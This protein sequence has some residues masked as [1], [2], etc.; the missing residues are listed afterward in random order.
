[1]GNG[2]HLWL[3]LIVVTALLCNVASTPVQAHGLRTGYLEIEDAGAGQATVRFRLPVIAPRVRPQ[4]PSD[5]RSKPLNAPVQ[6]DSGVVT[7]YLV[8]CERDL[9]GREVKIAGLGPAVSEA[10]VYYVSPTGEATAVLL[11]RKQDT[12]SIP[13]ATE[14]SVRGLCWHYAQLGLEH[15]GSGVDHLLFVA[16]LVL[17]LQRIRAVLTA[18]LAFT[19]SHTLSYA[20]TALGWLRLPVPATEACIA[21]SLVLLALD[22]DVH[23]RPAVP[24]AAVTIWLPLCFGL[25]HGLG[26][27]GGLQDVG[28]PA[29]HAGLATLGFGLGVELGQLASALLLLG[30]AWLASRQRVYIPIKYAATYCIGGTATYWFFTRLAVVIG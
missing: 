4:L 23:K 7:S 14:A 11:S 8:R 10:A 3:A 9:A 26:F 27:A 22:V 30:V 17:S 1:M 16:L 5:C 12:W 19:C 15:I 6:T 21:L 24:T 29:E 2:G 13:S 25:V 18:E 28:L 20:A